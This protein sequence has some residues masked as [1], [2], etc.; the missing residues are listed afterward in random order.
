MADII[1]QKK[2]EIDIVLDCEQHILYE[3][4][5][6]YSFDVEGASFSPALRCLRKSLR[7]TQVNPIPK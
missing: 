2:N 6:A 1:I 4:Q 7:Y 3:L 5:E